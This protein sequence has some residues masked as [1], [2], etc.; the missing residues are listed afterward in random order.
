MIKPDVKRSLRVLME[1]A[2]LFGLFPITWDDRKSYR[3]SFPFIVISTLKCLVYTVV[4]VVYFSFDFSGGENIVL[5]TEIDYISMLLTNAIPIV[6]I[7]ELA[8]TLREFNE[9]IFFL[10][11]AELQLLQLGKF[12][13]YDTSRRSLLANALFA[14][15]AM[16]ARF[17][18]NAIIDPVGIVLSGGQVLV[19]FSLF[20]HM[21]VL[22]YWYF[23]VVG[24]LTDLFAAC[25]QEV[26]NYVSDFVVLKMRKVEK[27]TRAHHTLCLCT[28]ILNEIHGVQLI[29]I[30]LS[31]FVIAV[32]EIYR[33]VVFLD[34]EVNVTF[35]LVIVVKLCL[36]TLCFNLCLQIVTACK[37][38][39]TEVCL[40]LLCLVKNTC[41]IS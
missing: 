19:N 26:R 40:L 35:F 32:T 2:K 7:C 27:L 17:V 22:V 15:V 20:C 21:I 12:V 30:F 11:A 37:A 4:T 16:V 24:I 31:C 10:E 6:S 9:C 18:K 39:S 38:C 33:C 34:E 25:N 5:S 28:T 14:S 23:G 41:F 1:P 36:I 3:I 8:F 29:V 13:D